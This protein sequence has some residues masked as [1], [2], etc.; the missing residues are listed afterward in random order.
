MAN[1]DE[2]KKEE[3]LKYAQK[4]EEH[5][6]QTKDEMTEK[7]LKE[8]LKA[9]KF[10]DREHFIKL[11]LWKSTR[12]RRWYEK[13]TNE[14]IIR[15]T[16]ACFAKNDE[17][18]RIEDLL[19]LYGVGY[20]VASVILH[21]VFP[22]EYSILDF[23]AIWSLRHWLGYSIKQPANYD[24]DFWIEYT[25]LLREL[26]KRYTLTIRAIDKALWEFSKEHQKNN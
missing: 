26:A 3:I 13:N 25:G 4:Y 7:E 20:P 12:P 2:M 11:G 19:K 6:R 23:R 5:F 9:H 17:R 8:W 24:F 14:E 18:G 15:I 1:L 16:R 22:D 10:L 21:F